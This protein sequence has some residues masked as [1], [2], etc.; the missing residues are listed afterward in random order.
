MMSFITNLT[1]VYT[2]EFFSFG[3]TFL[4]TFICTILFMI[5]RKKRKLYAL[6]IIVCLVVGFAISYL[7]A[8]YNTNLA[9]SPYYLFLRV[10]CYTF[11]SVF[12]LA[13]LFI[14]YNESWEELLLCWCSG[15]AVQTA[16]NKLYPLVQNI[17][18]VDDR[19]TI[20]FSGSVNP[21]DFDWLIFFGSKLIAQF[22][23]AF[24]FRRK[25]K[26]GR[27]HK[28]SKDIA[29]LSAGTVLVVNVLICVARKY[30]AKSF[31]LNLVVKIFSIL[32]SIV[33]LFFCT[34]ILTQNKAAQ[35]LSVLRQLWHQEQ[36]Q[37]ENIK[38]N[39]DVINMKCHDL[40]HMFT[41]L[42]GKLD[43]TEI[44]DLKSAIQFYDQTI[45]T[46]NE[47]LDVA[48]CE[49]MM[50]CGKNGIR[51]TCLADG[52]TLGFLTA[53]QIYSL[54]G[55]IIDNAIEAVKKLDDPEKKV[56][57]LTVCKIDDN[58]E[59]DAVNYFQGEFLY[60]NGQLTTSKDDSAKHGYGIKSIR[61]I[62]EQYGGSM[63]IS[64]LKSQ[65]MLKVIFP[66]S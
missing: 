19:S 6:R 35:E 49:K 63:S 38:A 58:I 14:C 56:I 60:E 52:S 42:E 7:A 61:Y 21:N 28:T 62:A 24:A 8:V 1:G 27:S 31:E 50:I 47:V 43:N 44:E 15:V 45:K 33:I 13:L 18:G 20:T 23:L 4:E 40:K 17:I 5:G 34:R 54:F 11:I 37:F 51:L 10:F 57:S 41:K 46:G 16:V 36:L 3:L 64:T 66:K 22:L 55:N 65:F 2:I 30:E 32:F 26:L 25:D 48:L 29:I 12:N 9:T 39:M 53:A 59:I